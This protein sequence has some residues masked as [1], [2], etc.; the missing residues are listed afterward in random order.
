MDSIYKIYPEFDHFYCDYP[1]PSSHS[2]SHGSL[3]RSPYYSV[4][5]TLMPHNPSQSQRFKTI[6]FFSFSLWISSTLA[7]VGWTPDSK[8]SSESL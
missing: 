5:T 1:G 8:L 6:T 3:Q 2:L 7:E 4:I